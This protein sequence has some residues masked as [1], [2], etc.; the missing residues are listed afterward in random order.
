[1]PVATGGGVDRT[2]RVV[3]LQE[4]APLRASPILHNIAFFSNFPNLFYTCRKI[5]RIKKLYLYL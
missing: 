4:K 3:V 1:M 2:V 5:W